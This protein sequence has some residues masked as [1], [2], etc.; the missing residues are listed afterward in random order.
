MRTV[1]RT[2]SSSSSAPVSVASVRTVM[3]RFFSPR[4]FSR[5]ELTGAAAEFTELLRCGAGPD[6]G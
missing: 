6:G 4:V 3:P 5:L 2:P 1:T